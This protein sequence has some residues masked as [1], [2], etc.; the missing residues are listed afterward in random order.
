[1]KEW[2]GGEGGVGLVSLDVIR[3]VKRVVLA[4][5][6]R[7]SEAVN[8]NKLSSLMWYRDVKSA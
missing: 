4:F 7:D 6:L 8:R 1:M 2:V 5:V 3:S